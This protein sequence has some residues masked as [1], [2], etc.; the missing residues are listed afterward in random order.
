MTLRETIEYVDSLDADDLADLLVTLGPILLG[1]RSLLVAAITRAAD[2][3][4]EYRAGL[5]DEIEQAIHEHIVAT[6][7]I[8]KEIAAA[9]L[10]G[11][12]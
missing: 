9:E 6:A 10:A 8:D 2:D 3:D 1:S 7:D 4:V 12:E 5:A 11:A